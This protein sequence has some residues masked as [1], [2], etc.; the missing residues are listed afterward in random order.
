M[1][2]PNNELSSSHIS[3]QQLR[4]LGIF[5]NEVKRIFTHVVAYRTIEELITD[6]DDVMRRFSEI[7]VSVKSQIKFLEFLN[8]QIPSTS[9][10]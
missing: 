3:I 1:K 4:K 10:I 8:S 9:E 7:F 5:R 2:T 6:I